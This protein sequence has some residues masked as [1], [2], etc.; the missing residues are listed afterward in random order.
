M[1]CIFCKI[2]SGDIPAETIFENQAARAFL[3]IHPVAIGHTVVIPKRHAETIIDMAGNEAASFFDAVRQATALIKKNLKPDGF[4]IGLNHGAIAGQAVPHVH[5]HIIPRFQGD[6]GS[7]IHG[8][9][10]APPAEPITV[11]AKRIRG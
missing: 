11:T 2:G 1:D 3:D 6:G 4:T 9:V 5:F 10:A 8:V 7:S